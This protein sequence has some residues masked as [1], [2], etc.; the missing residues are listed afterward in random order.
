MSKGYQK[1]KAHSM[2]ITKYFR[3]YDSK[4]RITKVIVVNLN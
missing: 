1:E 2:Q 3:K 4:V